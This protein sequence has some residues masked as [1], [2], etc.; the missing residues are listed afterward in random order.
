M[1]LLKPPGN[2]ALDGRAKRRL[3]W[4]LAERR[5]LGDLAED[6]ERGGYRASAPAWRRLKAEARQRAR[7]G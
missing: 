6:H 3:E 5:I 2:G 7:S 1:C 4:W